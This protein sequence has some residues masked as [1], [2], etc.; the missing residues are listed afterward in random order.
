M[1][2][3]QGH[4]DKGAASRL[5]PSCLLLARVSWHLRLAKRAVLALSC[6]QE[7]FTILAGLQA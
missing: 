5:L 1:L 3:V 4:P 7:V 2:T 6:W